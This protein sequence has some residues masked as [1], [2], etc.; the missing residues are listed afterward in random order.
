[1][2]NIVAFYDTLRIRRTNSRLK[3]PAPSRGGHHAEKLTHYEKLIDEL[4]MAGT[5]Y[6]ITMNQIP[7]FEKQNE[8]SVNVFGMENGERVKLRDDYIYIKSKS[9]YKT[10]LES[11]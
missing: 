10:L 11:L 8:I 3:P 5:Q 1:M 9:F 4:N 6:P 2:P 7:R